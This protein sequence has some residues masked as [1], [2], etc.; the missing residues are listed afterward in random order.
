MSAT[1]PR[2]YGCASH[3]SEREERDG[4]RWQGVQV[5]SLNYAI[6]MWHKSLQKLSFRSAICKPPFAPHVCSIAVALISAAG[7]RNATH[8]H[9][10]LKA[11]RAVDVKKP[12]QRYC[13]LAFPVASASLKRELNY[14][15]PGGARYRP[16]QEVKVIFIHPFIHP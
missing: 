12:N 16:M 14:F 8:V 10:L 1:S 4:R 6:H 11:C 9:F 5:A 7:K 15:W 3:K 2:R 13:S